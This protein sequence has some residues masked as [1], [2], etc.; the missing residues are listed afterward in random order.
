MGASETERAAT[1]ALELS[2]IGADTQAYFWAVFGVAWIYLLRGDMRPARELAEQLIGMAER[3]GNSEMLSYAHY[4]MGDTLLCV[5]ELSAA[6]DHV[7]RAIALYD[8]EWGHAAAFQH[9]LDCASCAHMFLA[10]LLWQLGY[11]DRALRVSQRAVELAKEVSHSFTLASTLSWKAA[12]HQLRREADRPRDMAE[13][14]LTLSTEQVFPF[15]VSHAMV[16]GGWALVEQ[17]RGDEG[18]LRLREGV[19]AYRMTESTLESPHWLTLLAEGC[20]KAGGIDEALK[21][22]RDGLTE[23]ERTGIA[24]HEAE[25]RRLERELCRGRD[26]ARAETC[27]HRALA[28]ARAQQAKSWELRAATSLARL[29]ADQGKRIEA[30]DLLAPVYDWFSEG[31]DTADLQAAKMLLAG[32]A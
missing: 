23:V 24:Y 1:R 28:I 11:P 12:L 16:L 30:R 15:F 18:L 32:L 19:E 2:R 4:N 3:L 20:G 14:A 10:R 7:E 8:P 13:A 17:G 26:D 29:W 6:K 9:G 5:G 21:I 22:L 27:F 31:L 25:M